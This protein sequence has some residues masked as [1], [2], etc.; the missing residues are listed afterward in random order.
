VKFGEP[1]QVPS[2]A[3]SVEPSFAVPLI[4]GG[5]LFVGGT[6]RAAEIAATTTAATAATA[7]TD[8][9]ALPNRVVFLISFR[10]LVSR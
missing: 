7:A 10:L 3:V 9:N 4:V 6:A 5:A 2:L 8:A 1:V